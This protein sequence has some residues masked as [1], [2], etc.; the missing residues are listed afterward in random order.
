MH[1][2][3]GFQMFRVVT[4]S[5]EPVIRIGDV[6]A[7]VPVR[8]PPRRFDILVFRRKNKAI[9]H[10]LWHIN[11]IPAE[12]GSP[13]FITRA[14]TGGEDLPVQATEVIG[15]VVSHRLSLSWKLRLFLRQFFRRGV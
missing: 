3:P 5:M 13:V 11:R 9:V 2:E 6:V 10:Y 12:D 8:L 7:V 4:G 15:S 14:L 1:D